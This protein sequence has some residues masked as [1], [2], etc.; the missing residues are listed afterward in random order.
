MQ[1][2]GEGGAQGIDILVSY[3]FRRKKE[4]KTNIWKK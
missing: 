2:V 1:T 3:M 4:E